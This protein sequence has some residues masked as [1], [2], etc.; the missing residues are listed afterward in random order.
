MVAAK[1]G[2]LY[3][4][5]GN[6]ADAA[7]ERSMQSVR[8]VYPEMPIHVERMDPV[9]SL[10]N[11]VRM[12][13]LSPFESTLYL[14]AD[15][16]VLGNLDFGFEKAEQFGLACCIC[17]C[18]WMRRYSHAHGDRIEYNT[19]VLFF[20]A[21]S[22][23]V[24]DAWEQLADKTPMTSTWINERGE[25]RWA[26]MDDQPSFALA[27]EACGVNPF[28]LP[29]N[30]NLRPMFHRSFFAPVKIWHEYIDPPP[31]LMEL[32]QACESG[33]RPVTFFEMFDPKKK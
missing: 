26:T 33:Q 14:D 17:E 25:P 4:V 16:I 18:P 24:F 12:A 13:V 6:G 2:I 20:T 1:R 30:F 27:V 5:W 31:G 9:R 22:R 8:A 32:S 19:G 29:I 23:P 15:T 11:K 3:I 28:V 7:L 21:K 10:L